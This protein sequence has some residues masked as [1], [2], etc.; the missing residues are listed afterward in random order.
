MWTKPRAA[1]LSLA[2]A[3]LALMAGCAFDISHVRQQPAVF[4]QAAQ[5]ASGFVLLR[6]TKATMG[7]GF[8][9]RLKAGTRWRQVGSIEQGAVFAT[10]DQVVMVE[11]SNNYEAQLVV[12]DGCL[13]GF[14]LPVERTFVAVSRPIPLSDSVRCF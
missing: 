6:E 1:G 2:L 7:T 3:S 14:Y 4:A 10:Q 12:A 5:P 8:P 9:T 13:K 11:A